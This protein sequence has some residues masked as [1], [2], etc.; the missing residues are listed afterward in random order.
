MLTKPPRYA[1]SGRRRANAIYFLGARHLCLPLFQDFAKLLA[2]KA[3]NWLS[4]GQTGVQ[5][6]YSGGQVHMSDP[7][8]LLQQSASL[9]NV[10]ERVTAESPF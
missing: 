8:V 5:T 7:E 6:G 1:A 3:R 2:N 4:A 9:G 10:I